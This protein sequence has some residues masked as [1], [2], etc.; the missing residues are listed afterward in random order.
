MTILTSYR[1]YANGFADAAATLTAA[2]WDEPSP[3][4]GWSARDVV[5]HLIGTQRDFF[6]ARGVSLPAAP[7]LGDPTLAWREHRAAVEALLDDP[8]TL[9]RKFETPF[10]SMTVGDGL[11][12]FY[13]FDMIAHRWDIVAAAGRDH[14]FSD[15]E[16][17]ILAGSIDG[18]GD[19]L[20]ADGICERTPVPTDADR[21]TTLLAKLGRR[22]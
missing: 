12:Q 17:D 20:Y 9:D 18:W 5:G 10:G 22:P 8:A 1:D 16:L 2:D 4:S 14:R 7:G 15:G 21:Q 6:A 19:A 11:L 13:G 3:C